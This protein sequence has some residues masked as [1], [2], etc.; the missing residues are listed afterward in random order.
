MTM[1]LEFDGLDELIDEI[2]RIEGLTSELKDEAL[3]AGGDLL[4]DRI[5][6]E[7]YSHG[8]TE[9]TGT[10]QESIVR[11]DPKNS[12]LFVGTDGGKKQPGFYLYMHEFGYYNVRAKRFIAPLPLVSIVYENNKNNILDEYVNVFRRGFGMS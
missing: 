9:R 5:Q 3:I 2:D 1:R 6:S 7:V 12:E 4:R 11:T 8:L 10:A